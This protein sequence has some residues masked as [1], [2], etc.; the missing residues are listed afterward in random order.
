MAT[1]I[2]AQER[3]RR[4]FT[5]TKFGL[6]PDGYLHAMLTVEGKGF[7]VDLKYGSWM[8]AGTENGKPVRKDVLWPYTE[9]LAAKAAKFRRAHA[10]HER[11]QQRERALAQAKMCVDL[12]YGEGDIL[13]AIRTKFGLTLQDAREIY[14]Q[15]TERPLEQVTA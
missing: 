14:Q 10:Q 2:E 4:G 11:D 3:T 7:Y 8:A 9:A 1:S 15:A 5:I 6:H 13:S 12:G